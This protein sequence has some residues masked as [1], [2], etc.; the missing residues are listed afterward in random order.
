MNTRWT[1]VYWLL[2]AAWAAGAALFMARVQ[3]GFFTNYLSD[4]AFPAWFYI[5]IRGLWQK[6]RKPPHL[7]L[8]GS[9]FG[10]SPERA[11]LSIFLFGLLTEL[12]TRHWPGGILSGT[13]DPWDLAAYAAGLLICYG[14]DKQEAR[15]LNA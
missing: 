6:D 7:L 10:R 12:K 13:F 3:G 4:L 1:P 9:W 8:A 2:L 15:R 5:H 11:G 14:F